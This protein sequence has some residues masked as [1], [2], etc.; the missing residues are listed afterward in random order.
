MIVKAGHVHPE[1][2]FFYQHALLWVR[3]VEAHPY[4][5]RW[6]ADGRPHQ[7][8]FDRWMNSRF[9]APTAPEQVR[10]LTPL[11]RGDTEDAP[12]TPVWTQVFTVYTSGKSI[13]RHAEWMLGGGERIPF[14][15]ATPADIVA[16]LRACLVRDAIAS[17]KQA[18]RKAAEEHAR[19]VCLLTFAGAIEA[20]GTIPT[21]NGATLDFML[22]H[23]ANP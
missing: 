9:S 1:V 15:K 13:T 6:K 8:D 14:T 21:D 20:A 11:I 18:Q 10:D 4:A 7:A 17:A 16:E 2:E 22:R 23:S 19:S 5:G 3:D 12:Y